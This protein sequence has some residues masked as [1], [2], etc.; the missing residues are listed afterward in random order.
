MEELVVRV[1]AGMSTS[2]PSLKVSSVAG[3]RSV[4]N[5]AKC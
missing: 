5:G 3:S 4:E 1:C 2:Q